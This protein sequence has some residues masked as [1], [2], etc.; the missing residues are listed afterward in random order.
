MQIYGY[1]FIMQ[2]KR[3]AIHYHNTYK[4]LLDFIFNH[5]FFATNI[6]FGY[7]LIYICTEIIFY[8]LTNI[9]AYENLYKIFVHFS[10]GSR[11]Y[12]SNSRE[13]YNHR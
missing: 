3:N 12:D 4:L 1:F 2:I 9:K 5:Q 6:L 8:Y 13:F 10:N 11:S 7:K